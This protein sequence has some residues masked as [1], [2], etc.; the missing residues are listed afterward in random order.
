MG[1]PEQCSVGE[2]TCS[3]ILASSFLVGTNTTQL[4]GKHTAC[5]PFLAYIQFC[6][7]LLINAVLFLLLLLLSV[8]LN[9]FQN[10]RKKGANLISWI[11]YG[12]GKPL[13]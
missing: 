1:Q 11:G 7:L 2:T 13:G 3:L 6:H 8:K 9:A 12:R 5:C 10:R 4:W